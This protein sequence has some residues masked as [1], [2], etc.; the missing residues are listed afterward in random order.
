ME[1]FIA[2]LH[3]LVDFLIAN[4]SANRAAAIDELQL[5]ANVSNAEG[6]AFIDKLVL[7]YFNA[8]INNADTWSSFR[9]GIVNSADDLKSKE[10][11]EIIGRGMVINDVDPDAVYIL[12]QLENKSA[13]DRKTEIGTE[14]VFLRDWRDDTLPT[15]GLS[16]SD[17]KTLRKA[18]NAGIDALVAERNFITV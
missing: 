7:Q 10:L 4:P 17:E 14:L 9:N 8:G 13:Q 6:G 18:V 3:S 11:I 2:Y 15:L 16:S 5:Q 1:I 12:T